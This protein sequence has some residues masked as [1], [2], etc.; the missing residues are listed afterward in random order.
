MPEI[1]DKD[2]DIFKTVHDRMVKEDK[3]G[4]FIRDLEPKDLGDGTAGD[5]GGAADKM[6]DHNRANDDAADK[7]DGTD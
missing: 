3:A 7:A 4:N 6:V 1:G 5:K 2:T